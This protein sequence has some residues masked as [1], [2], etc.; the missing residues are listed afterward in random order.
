[1]GRVSLILTILLFVL[2]GNIGIQ[3][4]DVMYFASSFRPDKAKTTSKILI[5][6]NDTIPDDSLTLYF[7]GNDYPE[8][9]SRNIHT[10]VCIDSLCRLVNITMYWELTGKYLGFSLS[11]G[12]ELTKREHVPFL[13]PDYTRLN[14]I[15]GDSSSQLGY[16]TP[17]EIHPVKVPAVNKTDEKSDGIT[18]ATLPDLSPWIVPEAAYTSYTLWHLVYGT[19]RDSIIAYTRDNLLSD[20][21]FNHLLQEKDP[22]SRIIGL[23]WLSE[24]GQT[25]DQYVDVAIQIL[26]S[27][28]YLASIQALKFLK[29]CNI[30]EERLQREVIKLLDSED[31]RIKNTAVEFLRTSAQLTQP[32]VSEMVNRLKSDNYYLVNLILTL[33]ERKVQPSF[34]DQLKLSLLLESKNVNVA[35]RV[36]YFLLNLPDQSPD[37]TKQLNRY[38]K[39]KQ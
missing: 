2:S 26:H 20:Q 25:G 14:E 30:G 17:L 29:K 16:Y 39:K 1:M 13:E 15:L 33:L 18:G 12:E 3:Q 24:T 9:F 32:V 23:Q 31:F 4:T 36:F 21:L 11:P 10:A 27:G 19:T 7:T 6:F 5:N 8:A 35:N 37:I 34:D 28:N 22:Y 38:E